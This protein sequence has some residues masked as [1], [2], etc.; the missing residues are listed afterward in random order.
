MGCKQFEASL[1]GV[2]GGGEAKDAWAATHISC[3]SLWTGHIP[4]SFTSLCLSLSWANNFGDS[5]SC[6]AFPWRSNEQ[7]IHLQ[8]CRDQMG[9]S[10]LDKCQ[11]LYLKSTLCC[12]NIHVSRNKLFW[13]LSERTQCYGILKKFWIPVI[14]FLQLV[15]WSNGG[16]QMEGWNLVTRLSERV[17]CHNTQALLFR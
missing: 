14:F 7:H 3:E 2:L 8:E 1:A 5:T 4:D 11:F 12:R 6:T 17:W 13:T 9:S 16:G 10:L 15:K